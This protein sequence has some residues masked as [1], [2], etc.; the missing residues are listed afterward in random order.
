MTASLRL[1][2]KNV[3][4]RFPSGI[5]LLMGLDTLLTMG[6]SSAGPFRGLPAQYA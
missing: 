5:W 6:W 4:R 2:N 1:I 3:F